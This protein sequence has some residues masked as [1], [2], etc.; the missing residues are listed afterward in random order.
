[1]DTFLIFFKR[2]RKGNEIWSVKRNQIKSGD[3]LITLVLRGLDNCK[4]YVT[5]EMSAVISCNCNYVSRCR[6]FLGGIPPTITS[7][8]ISFHVN[9]SPGALLFVWILSGTV[10]NE[11]ILRRCDHS[12]SGL[13]VSRKWKVWNWRLIK[14]LGWK[15]KNVFAKIPAIFVEIFDH[16]WK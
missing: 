7:S 2:T 13:K 5:R 3:W 11:F 8:A 12:L 15:V 4:R 1:M 6:L 16:E 14:R 9:L 10:S